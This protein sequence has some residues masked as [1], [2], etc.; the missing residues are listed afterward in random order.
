MKKNL[1][2]GSMPPQAYGCSEA[3]QNRIS[4]NVFALNHS[5]LLLLFMKEFIQIN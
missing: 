1:T 2:A 4:D 5:S 3:S